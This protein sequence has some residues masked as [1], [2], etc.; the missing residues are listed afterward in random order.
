MAA[1]LL[2][3]LRR[4]DHASDVFR[5]VE[6]GEVWERPAQAAYT[7][8]K[9]KAGGIENR[10]G[11][12]YN[13]TRLNNGQ[14]TILFN[15]VKRVFDEDIKRLKEK[16]VASREI[17]ASITDENSETR[18][19]VLKHLRTVSIRFHAPNLGMDGRR[20]IVERITK[21][22]GLSDAKINAAFEDMKATIEEAIDYAGV[23]YR[24]LALDARATN[25]HAPRIRSWRD[26]ERARAQ[27]E[28]EPERENQIKGSRSE[29][30]DG[31]SDA[32]DSTHYSAEAEEAPRKFADKAFLKLT[33]RNHIKGDKILVE[34]RKVEQPTLGLMNY[35]FSSPSRIASKVQRFRLFWRMADR[36][37]NMLT[38][39]RSYYARKL[40]E[41]MA[42]VKN[43]ADRQVLYDVL[44]TGDAEGREY[45]RQELADD[46]ISDNVI[47]AY[48]RIRRLMTRA[49]F[50]KGALVYEISN[51]TIRKK[52]K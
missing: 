6:S 42:F 52:T 20:A 31:F 28:T 40:E 3:V 9:Y 36:A 22:N 26:V 8:V 27:R 43:K 13:K 48:T 10:K 14:R 2:R 47:E 45:T 38:K 44:L 35:I 33:R 51:M 5:R 39:N 46:G 16:G 11:E 17:F 24:E 21:Q 23:I 41:A 15:S 30:Q 25:G 1:G 49:F 7:S 50:K 19:K 18:E 32:D 12:G 29:I 37:M 34:E 4:A